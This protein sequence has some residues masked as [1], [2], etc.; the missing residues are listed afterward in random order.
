M[1]FLFCPALWFA[2]LCGFCVLM[3]TEARESSASKFLEQSS[4]L[5][6]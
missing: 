6:D 1:I 3:W 4:K 5:V 2:M